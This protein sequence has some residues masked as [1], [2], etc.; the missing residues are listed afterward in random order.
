MNKKQMKIIALFIILAQ[1]HQIE[2][3]TFKLIRGHDFLQI[4]FL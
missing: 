3:C 1:R 2:I 4:D